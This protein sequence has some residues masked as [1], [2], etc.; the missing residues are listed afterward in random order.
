MNI[1]ILIRD[2]KPMMLIMDIV[3]MVS[4][5]PI[6]LPDWVFYHILCLIMWRPYLNDIHHSEGSSCACWIIHSHYLSSGIPVY[7]KHVWK[8]FRRRCNSLPDNEVWE[9]LTLFYMT[10]CILLLFFYFDLPAKADKSRML[11]EIEQ[12][13]SQNNCSSLFWT[14]CQN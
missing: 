9:F 4:L 14:L 6:A 10:S 11:A 2:I 3:L 5:V 1:L 13:L 7:C 12:H 8:Q